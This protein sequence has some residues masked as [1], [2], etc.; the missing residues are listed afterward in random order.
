MS[1]KDKSSVSIT[2]KITSLNEKIAWFYSDDFSIDSALENYKSSIA[3][4]N[5][6]KSDLN[7][8]KNEIEIISK[9]FTA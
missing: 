4:A 5:E 9:N 2:E 7:N 3:L 8:L 1:E 6:I